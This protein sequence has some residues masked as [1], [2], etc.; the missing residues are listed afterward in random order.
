M[1]SM[2]IKGLNTDQ[3]VDVELMFKSCVSV[4][5]KNERRRSSLWRKH[6]GSE[7]RH[8]GTGGDSL[9]QTGRAFFGI[10][11]QERKFFKEA[12]PP[13]T[14]YL[15]FDICMLLRRSSIAKRIFF[16]CCT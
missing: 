6:N 9:V 11:P 8:I 5:R 1:I 16:A 7:V 4:Q 12:A 3:V 13:F 10:L 15:V 2:H 14:A